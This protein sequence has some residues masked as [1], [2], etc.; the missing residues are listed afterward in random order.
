VTARSA[1]VHHSVAPIVRRTSFVRLIGIDQ[2]E[3]A[4]RRYASRPA[5]GKSRGASL[6][7]RYGILVV[8]MTA[9]DM[10]RGETSLEKI[11]SGV[12]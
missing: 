2:Q 3:G 1:R 11:D 7:D 8:R 10:R 5:A 9:K 12:K 4:G 6:D